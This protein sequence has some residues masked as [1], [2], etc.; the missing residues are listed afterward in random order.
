M[1][2]FCT[3]I[4][5]LVQSCIVVCDVQA[6]R[7]LCVGLCVQSHAILLASLSTTSNSLW[8]ALSQIVACSKHHEK[9]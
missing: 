8:P 7:Q 6:V 5:H 9:L 2:R 3:V 1:S 4:D